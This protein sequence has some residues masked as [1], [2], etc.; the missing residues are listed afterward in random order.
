MGHL[1]TE[2]SLQFFINISESYVDR[3]TGLPPAV[4]HCVGEPKTTRGLLLVEYYC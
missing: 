4:Y 3:Y 2:P 1:A